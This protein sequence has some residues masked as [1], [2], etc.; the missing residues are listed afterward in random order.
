M[1]E[2]ILDFVE[3]SGISLFA[4]RYEALRRHDRRQTPRGRA[5]IPTRSLGPRSPRSS[6]EA[7]RESSQ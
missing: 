5:G 4:R 2:F 6:S 3:A 1:L 7:R